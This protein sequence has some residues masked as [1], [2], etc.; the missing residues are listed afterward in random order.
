MP[1]LSSLAIGLGVAGAA[2][3]VLGSVFGGD[4]SKTTRSESGVELSQANSTEM[5]AEGTQ[6]TALY[7][8]QQQVGAGA[9]LSDVAASTKSQRDLASLFGQAS[10]NGGLPGQQDINASQSFAQQ[11]F[12]P[13]RVALQQ[14]LQDQS[15]AA[16]RSGALMGRSANDPILRAKLAQEQTR[17]Q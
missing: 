11:I 7:E 8:L 3:G 9:G 2:S 13:Q 16:A 10:Q 1:A 4:S 15:Q 6:N 5:N 14:N 17:Q 12:N